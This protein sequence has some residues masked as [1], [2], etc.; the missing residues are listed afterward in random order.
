MSIYRRFRLLHI[1]SGLLFRRR[2]CRISRKFCD[3]LHRKLVVFRNTKVMQ[4]VEIAVVFISLLCQLKINPIVLRNSSTFI[5]RFLEKH[6]HN[7]VV[8][9][10]LESAL[11]I[12]GCLI[13]LFF[14]TWP[15]LRP[16]NLELSQDCGA[17]NARR[18]HWNKTFWCRYI[19]PC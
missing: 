17:I 3:G 4:H 2:R 7:E 13:L 11:W 15:I 18:D 19:S 1:F 9:T 10:E 14:F 12:W 5:T 8:Y 16:W 6:S